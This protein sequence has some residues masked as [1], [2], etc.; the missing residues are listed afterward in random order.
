MIEKDDAKKEKQKERL[1][2]SF[3]E[4]RKSGIALMATIIALSSGGLAGLMQIPD[5]R[6]LA[7]LYLIP[8]SLAV[9]QQ[10]AHYLGSKAAAQSVY[11]DFWSG[12][13][14]S[15]SEEVEAHIEGSVQFMYSNMHFG[16]A[17]AFSISA[18]GSLWIVTLLPLWM[19]SP[20]IVSGVVIAATIA[21]VS[22][23]FWKRRETNA[24]IQEI[25]W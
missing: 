17:D 7:F 8:I 23:W 10:L 20:G 2:R 13:Y 3:E 6:F 14:Q 1:E 25:E 5:A 24:R 11:S 21:V 22:F 16:V 18:C 9:L 15:E 4:Y 19:L 12:H